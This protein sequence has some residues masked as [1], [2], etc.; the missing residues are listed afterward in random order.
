MSNNK[1]ITGAIVPTVQ[2]LASVLKRAEL[3]R[4][5]ADSENTFTRR[6]DHSHL[7]KE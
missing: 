3:A 5:N 2:S 7:E 1:I 4:V 6:Q